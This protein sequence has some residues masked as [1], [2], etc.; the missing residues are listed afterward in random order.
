MTLYEHSSLKSKLLG[1]THSIWQQ[2]H[3]CIDYVLFVS[4][5]SSLVHPT[6]R[7]HTLR[8]GTRQQLVSP[9]IIL[10]YVDTDEVAI[11]PVA[12]FGYLW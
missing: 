3:L 7:N 8:Y 10:C 4:L 2:W 6:V 1:F 5:H 11:L 12:L 9:Y